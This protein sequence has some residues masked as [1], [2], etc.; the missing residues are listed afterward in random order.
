M[1]AERKSE[2]QFSRKLNHRRMLPS[3]ILNLRAKSPS[4]I[5]PCK[6][7]KDRRR[8]RHRGAIPSGAI[9]SWPRRLTATEWTYPDR[10]MRPPV[11]DGVVSLIERMAWENQKTDSV[12]LVTSHHYADGD[13]VMMWLQRCGWPSR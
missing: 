3:P 8:L 6:H 4:G 11:E 2:I 7:G 13:T 1:P 12:L 5:V 10:L 9:D